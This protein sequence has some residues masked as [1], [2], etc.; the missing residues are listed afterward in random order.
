[1][2]EMCFI[3]ATVRHAYT[4]VHSLEL[5]HTS[6]FIYIIYDLSASCVQ[7]LHNVA[8][9]VVCVCVCVVSSHDVSDFL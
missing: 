3:Y 4:F 6:Y 7:D 8:K 9:C 5:R 2:Y 1:M